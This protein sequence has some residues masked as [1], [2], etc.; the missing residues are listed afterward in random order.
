MS[1]YKGKIYEDGKVVEVTID[2]SD[3]KEATRIWRGMGPG[4]EKPAL[5]QTVVKKKA[6]RKKKK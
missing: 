1:T 2:A 4:A 6:S 5:Q 3:L